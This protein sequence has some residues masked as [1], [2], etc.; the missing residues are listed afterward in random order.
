MR[1][2]AS[3]KVPDGKLVNVEVKYGD[4]FENVEIRGDFFIEPPQ[5]LQVF[6]SKIEGLPADSSKE[7]ILQALSMVDADLIGFSREVLVDVLMEAQGR[8]Q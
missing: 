3:R 7:E 4:V 5:A 2:E 1:G 8:N 6:E